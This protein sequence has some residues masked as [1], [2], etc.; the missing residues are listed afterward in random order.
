MRTSHPHFSVRSLVSCTYPSPTHITCGVRVGLLGALFRSICSV[1]YL[2]IHFPT[3]YRYFLLLAV[4]TLCEWTP[5]IYTDSESL[6][7]KKDTRQ[8]T[9]SGRLASND[10]NGFLDAV[11]EEELDEKNGGQ[12]INLEEIFSQQ[13][14]EALNTHKV[15]QF[16]PNHDTREL[17]QLLPIIPYSPKAWRETKS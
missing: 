7:R 13:I 14:L 2:L 15:R 8:G 16:L 9:A 6:V 17:V 1:V 12:S 4:V 3:V 11:E 5:N 10:H